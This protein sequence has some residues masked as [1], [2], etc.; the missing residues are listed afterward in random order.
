MSNE[1]LVKLIQTGKNEYISELWEN[2]ERFVRKQANSYK[3]LFI[4]YLLYKKFGNPSQLWHRNF[5][6][7]F[8]FRRFTSFN[9]ALHIRAA[10]H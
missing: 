4:V 8:P 3:T 1:E 7:C 9:T 6:L 10:K 2:V 5:P